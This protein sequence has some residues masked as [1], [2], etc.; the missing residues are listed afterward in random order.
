[1]AFLDWSKRGEKNP[2]GLLDARFGHGVTGIFAWGSR[3]SDNETTCFLTGFLLLLPNLAPK[4]NG[5]LPSK[6]VYFRLHPNGDLGQ[7]KPRYPE[8]ARLS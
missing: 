5:L 2:D 6:A 4:K 3:C 1:M 7:K 8:I